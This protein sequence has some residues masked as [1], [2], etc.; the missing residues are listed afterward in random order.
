[1]SVG[2]TEYI[3][4]RSVRDVCAFLQKYESLQFLLLFAVRKDSLSQKSK[5]FS[6]I[7]TTVEPAGIVSKLWNCQKKKE[8]EPVNHLKHFRNYT[9]ST[10]AN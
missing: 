4:T 7:Y 10:S 1:M 9:H 5:L 3:T 2:S 6:K 8:T